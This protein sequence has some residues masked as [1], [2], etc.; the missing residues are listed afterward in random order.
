M[1]H[2]GVFC[3]IFLTS[4]CIKEACL[5]A[6]W[7]CHYGSWEDMISDHRHQLDTKLASLT[8]MVVEDTAR[9]KQGLD[10][11]YRRLVTLVVLRSGL[12]NPTD[13]AVLSEANNCL[14][15]V[16]PVSQLVTFQTM[17]RIEKKTKLRQLT[18]LVKGLRKVFS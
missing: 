9:T 18:N 7:L 8:R 1:K 11:L 10:S 17:A 5:Q 2:P 16:F 13:P 12:G 3:L 4:P 6:H 15:T 14:A